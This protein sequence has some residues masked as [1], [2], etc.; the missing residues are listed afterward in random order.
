MFSVFAY[1]EKYRALWKK[2]SADMV[3]HGVEIEG[4]AVWNQ[5]KNDDFLRYFKWEAF[6]FSHYLA[7]AVMAAVVAYF[8][9]RF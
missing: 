4:E 1:C 2:D 8:A 6:H 9:E 7:Q 3:S 5:R